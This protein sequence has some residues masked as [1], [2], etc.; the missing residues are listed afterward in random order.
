MSTQ[1]EI[2]DFH[3]HWFPPAV[4]ATTPTAPLPPAVGRVWPLLLDLEAQ[5]DAA[6]Q[7]GIGL[8]VVNAV[9]GGI[10]A[11]ATVP[12][13]DLPARTNDVLAEAQREHSGRLLTLATIDAFRGDEAAEEARRAVDELGL[14]GLALDAAQGE[15]LLSA[16][17]ARPTLAFAAERGIPVFAHPVNPPVLPPRYADQNHAGVLLARGAESALSTLALLDSGI[18]DELPG[19]NI[20]LA[21]IGAP[22]LLLAPFLPERAAAARGRLFVDTMGFDPAATRFAIDALGADHVLIGSDWPIIDR[23]ASVERVS[24]LLDATGVN[25]TD[26]ALIAGGNA[27]RLLGLAPVA[28]AA[29]Q[30]E[31]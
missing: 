11:V 10:A 28:V 23:N 1:T 8:K 29:S 6:E 30:R 26:R 21:G 14:R 15:L 5:L 16:P 24:A 9:Y 12:L 25:D 19:L 31:R 17:E 13:A 18:F 7:A 2:V 27:Q 4:V 22:A 20:V 3:G